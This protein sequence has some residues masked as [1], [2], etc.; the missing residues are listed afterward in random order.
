[1]SDKRVYLSDPVQCAVCGKVLMVANA[2][3]HKGQYSAIEERPGK[4]V[5]EKCS[6]WL[7]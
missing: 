4:Y 2:G 3:K 5:H 6:G 7:Q 1:M